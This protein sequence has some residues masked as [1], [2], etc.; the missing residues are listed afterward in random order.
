MQ[1]NFK[2]YS[3]EYKTLYENDHLPHFSEQYLDYENRI[4]KPEYEGVP[5][6]T[7]E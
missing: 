4:F 5:Y 6:E 7:P 2:N 1:D 3:N